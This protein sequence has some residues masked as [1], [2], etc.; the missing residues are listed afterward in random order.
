MVA[1]L[2]TDS[3]QG[4]NER[5]TLRWSAIRAGAADDSKSSLAL[6]LARALRISRP[7]SNPMK[8]ACNMDLHCNCLDSDFCRQHSQILVAAPLEYNITLSAAS[9][10]K[11]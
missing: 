10:R 4:R 6:L 2:Q 1:R 11:P 5:E 9:S 7:A 8:R 3:R